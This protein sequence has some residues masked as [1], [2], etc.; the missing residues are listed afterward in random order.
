MRLSGLFHFDY[1]TSRAIIFFSK[2]PATTKITPSAQD[3]GGIVHNLV[4]VHHMRTPLT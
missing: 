3:K 1:F 4:L 2:A